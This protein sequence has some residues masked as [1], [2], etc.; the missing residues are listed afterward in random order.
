ML[1]YP[2]FENLF[3][4]IRRYI[5]K[6]KIEVADKKTSNYLFGLKVFFP[7]ST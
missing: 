6:S 3:S 4:I 1:W 7:N 2:A 5:Y